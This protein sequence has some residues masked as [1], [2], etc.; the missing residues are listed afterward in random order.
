M[1]VRDDGSSYAVGCCSYTLLLDSRTLQAIKK[2]PSRYSGCGKH[3]HDCFM[4]THNVFI[5]V[6]VHGYSAY[7]CPAYRGFERV[8]GI[9]WVL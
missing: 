1:A 8:F 9:Q 4:E 5:T 6:I 3:N 7:F 2:I